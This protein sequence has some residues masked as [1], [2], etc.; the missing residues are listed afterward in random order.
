MMKFGEGSSGKHI[1]ERTTQ[2][3]REHCLL[4]MYGKLVTLAN[5]PQLTTI[6]R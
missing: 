6:T 5:D 3:T 4:R 1:N 2:T